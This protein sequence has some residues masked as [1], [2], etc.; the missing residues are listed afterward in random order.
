MKLALRAI[1][2]LGLLVNAYIHVDLASQYDAVT[3]GTISQGDL[4]RIQAGAGLLAAVLVVALR[5]RA[6]DLFAL[7]VA[8]GGIFAVL[9]YRYVEVGQIGPL[10]SMYEPVWYTE[11]ALSLVAQAF[12]AAAAATLLVLGVRQPKN[13][14][15]DHEHQ[16]ENR[17]EH[18]V[19]DEH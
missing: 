8:A 5:R 3:S 6:S 12:V 16:A 2:A 19:P 9:L 14:G 18:R 1:V 11:K 4:F 17:R 15:V 10:P 13:S 7:A